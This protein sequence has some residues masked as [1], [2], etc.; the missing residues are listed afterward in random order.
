MKN[1]M[2]RMENIT[3]YD[4]AG[5]ARHLEKMAARGWMLES[6]SNFTWR[7]RRISPAK[8]HFAVTYFPISTRSRPSSSALSGSSVK[9]RGGNTLYPGRRCRSL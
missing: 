4:P 7:Y 3:F 9:W 1:T 5:I 6:C 2:R 8:L